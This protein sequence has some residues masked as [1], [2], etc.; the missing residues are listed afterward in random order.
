M[1]HAKL[2][3]WEDLLVETVKHHSKKNRNEFLELIDKTVN[4]KS[5]IASQP[6]LDVFGASRD[7]FLNTIADSFLLGGMPI[8]TVTAP[9][10]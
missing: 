1:A 10:F 2:E 3:G 6:S 5:K 9:Y 7:K 8:S 4:F